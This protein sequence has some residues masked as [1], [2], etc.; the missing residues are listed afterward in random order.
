MDLSPGCVGMTHGESQSFNPSIPQRQ[1]A[2]LSSSAF[3]AFPGSPPAM[4]RPRPCPGRPDLALFARGAIVM[5]LVTAYP[6]VFLSLRKQAGRL[7][8]KPPR[9]AEKPMGCWF[10]YIG[11]F[12]FF[13]YFFLFFSPKA[14]KNEQLGRSKGPKFVTLGTGLPESQ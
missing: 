1:T 13:S 11:P 9:N 5:S 10:G 6:L 14:W 12:S 8:G 3:F 4:T 7:G 2:I